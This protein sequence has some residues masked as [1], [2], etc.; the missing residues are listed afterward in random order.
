MSL[1][2]TLQSLRSANGT[3]QHIMLGIWGVVIAGMYAGMG[4]PDAL[5]VLWTALSMAVIGATVWLS[6][7]ILKRLLIADVYISVA[8]LVLYLTHTR[9]AEVHMGQLHHH[10]VDIGSHVVAVLILIVHGLYLAD[11]TNRQILERKRFSDE[12]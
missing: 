1:K 10:H 11:L 12:Q 3:A 4:V 7:L 9:H 8:V 6:K 5:L 2:K